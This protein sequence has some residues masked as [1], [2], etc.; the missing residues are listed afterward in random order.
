MSSPD[1]NSDLRWAEVNAKIN[2]AG[3]LLLIIFLLIAIAFKLS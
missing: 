1:K 2:I 3:G